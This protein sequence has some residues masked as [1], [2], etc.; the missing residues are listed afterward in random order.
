MLAGRAILGRCAKRPGSCKHRRSC[1]CLDVHRGRKRRADR[2]CSRPQ[3][4]QQQ[5]PDAIEEHG[6]SKWLA[7]VR[8]HH[9][10]T[11]QHCLLVTGLAVD[12]GLSLGFPK[13][14]IE[15]LHSAAMFHDIGKATIPFPFSTNPAGWTTES[16]H[17]SRHIRAPDMTS[18]R[19]TVRSRLK[20][21][22]EFGTITNI[23]TEAAILTNSAPK[24]S[25][26]LSAC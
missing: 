22:T 13:K 17:S 7:T 3:G 21:W 16:A 12:F 18:S 4:R 1:A 24:A 2:C 14:D 15:R 6:L 20:S 10:G 11:Y 25:A 23:S 19:T 9:E 26:T 8:K 5:S